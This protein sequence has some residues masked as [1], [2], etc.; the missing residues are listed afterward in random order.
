MFIKYLED[1]IFH[2]INVTEYNNLSFN[3]KIDENKDSK[4]DDKEAVPD[5]KEETNNKKVQYK[6]KKYVMQALLLVIMPRLSAFLSMSIFISRLSVAIPRLS[7]T[8]LELSA[9]IS[10]LSTTVLDYL[11]LR[12]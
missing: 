4:K 12:L 8:M 6:E 10:R 3:Y 9:A 5:L 7:T 2:F 11:L 1:G